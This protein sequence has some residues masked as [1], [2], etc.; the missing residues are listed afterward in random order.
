MA[1]AMQPWQPST[2]YS[3]EQKAAK[4]RTVLQCATS[5][6][7]ALEAGKRLI[8]QW[9]HSKPAD[10]ETYAASIAAVLAQYPLGLVHECVDP[11]AGLARE[12]E[13]P[14]TVAAVVEWCDRRL[15][16]H[17]TVAAYVGPPP[18][19]PAIAP[20]PVSSEQIATLLT[21]LAAELRANT[22]RSPLDELL[23]KAGEGRR[24]RIE[25]V[26]RVA[27]QPAGTTE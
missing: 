8:G 24:L 15:A 6:R 11:R 14:P 12:R 23:A 1:Q 18:T 2:T 17:Q 13:F 9:P 3:L 4:S 19:R 10:P 26:Q 22:T 25:E 7:D 21:N 5:P 27:Q 20:G 16:W